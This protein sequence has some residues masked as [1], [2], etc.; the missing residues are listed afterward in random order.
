VVAKRRAFEEIIVAIEN[1]IFD[2][3]LK[4]GD[5]LPSERELAEI[6]SV[7]RPSVREALRVLESFGVLSARRG[8]GAD[9]GSIVSALDTTPLSGLLRM[10]ATLLHMPLTDLLEMREGIEVVTA[11]R[12]AERATPEQVEELAAIVAA[13]RPGATPAEFLALDTEFHLLLARISG[14]AVAPLILHA[15][16]DAI[17]R[18]VLVAF[19]QLVA[20]GK[21]ATELAWLVRE[22]AEL[23]AHIRG[24][25][26]EAAAAAFGQH[27]HNFYGRVIQPSEATVEEPAPVSKRR[28]ARRP[29]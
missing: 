26:P 21:W 11:R 16:R 27:V 23:V 2:G 15:L 9:S 17:A 18:Q 4:V 29:A 25:D 8:T 13:M 5:R 19:E 3:R 20:A 10:H 1:D 24:G 14:N 12:A 22:H 28:A 7:S 6:F